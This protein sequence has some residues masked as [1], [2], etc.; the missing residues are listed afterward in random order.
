MRAH[1]WMS[2]GLV[3]AMVVGVA[4]CESMK[5]KFT[6]KPRVQQGPEPIFALEREYR[7]EFSPEVRYQAHFAYWKAAHGDLL[8]GLGQ[9][10][11]ARR[12]H[13]VRE[14]LK[15]LRAMQALL[16]GP[17]VTGLGRL[18]DELAA[19]EG[20]LD[21]PT[22]DASRLAFLHATV[23]SLRRRIDRGYAYHKMKPSL[24]PDMPAQP[25]TEGSPG[26]ATSTMPA[27][28]AAHDAPAR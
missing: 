26:G 17:P 23:E 1:R 9:V 4:G 16:E 24:K 13:A 14:A 12:M 10:T 15:E 3:V 28:G 20:P 19:L 5:R 2:V 11:R 6:R 7:P 21:D 22:L 25:A 8:E 27:E 18:I